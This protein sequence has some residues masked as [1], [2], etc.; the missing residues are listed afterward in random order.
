MDELAEYNAI[1]KLIDFTLLQNRL[2][3]FNLKK[4][5]LAIVQDESIF[6]YDTKTKKQI[7]TLK[8]HDGSISQLYFLPDN[9]HL[10]YAT[11]NGRVVICNYKN[12]HYTVRLFSTIKKYKTQ[13]PIR[14]SAIAFY[15]HLLAVGSADGKVTLIH[16]NSYAIIDE[17]YYSNAA[18]STLCFSD[19]NR[20]IIIDAHGEIFTHD[21]ERIQTTTS[22]MTHLSH[23]KQLLQIPKSDFLLINS[24]KEFLTLFDMKKNKVILNEYL[25]F[26]HPIS[27]IELTKEHNLLVALEDREVLHI[28]LQNESNLESLV[29]H[30]MIAEAY[31]L[32]EKNPQLLESKEYKELEKAYNIKYLNALKALQL[33]DVKKAQELLENCSEIKSKQEDTK[34]LFEAYRYYERFQ[35]LVME[36]KFAPAYALATKYPPL[37]YSKEYKT[38]ENAYKNA[39]KN[40][41]KQVLLSNLNAAKELLLPYLSVL[42]KKES[43]NL[44]LKENEAFLAFLEAL[45][46]SDYATMHKLLATH[47]H[48]ENIPPYKEFLY[49]IKD[50]LQK[51]NTLLNA[52]DIV[53]AREL[54][55]KLENI[56]FIQKELELL[57]EK[58]DS[59]EKLLLLYKQNKFQECYRVLDEKPTIFLN[60]KLANL[61]EKHWMKLMQKCEKYALYGNVKGIKQTLQEL[62]TLQSRSKRVGEL[63]R[64]AFIVEIDDNITKKKFVSAENFIYS[65]VDIFGSDTNLQRVMQLYEKKAKKKLALT[66]QSTKIARD[67]WLHNKLILS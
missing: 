30:N 54:M 61:L 1:F 47:P 46:R 40:A 42:S 20:L 7:Q 43:I 22:V 52:A 9:L 26:T 19:T 37:Q 5:V 39:Y 10:V 29:L 16:L 62:L 24:H 48:F 57:V 60:L 36:K 38:M 18:V 28:T 59:I 51:I 50:S 64:V 49:T 15:K 67:A 13:L 34:L 8:S 45:K 66:P 53:Q 23:T 6:I 41:Q 25:H 63:L 2:T 11:S 44:I 12:A 17:L 3:A 14:I 56:S 31:A 65:Y 21:L 27:Y 35:A 32:V 55:Q 33:C 4:R 58:A